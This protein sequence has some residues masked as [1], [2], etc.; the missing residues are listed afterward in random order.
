[1][2]NDVIFTNNLIV[3]I[4]KIKVYVQKNKT[5][6]YSTITVIIALACSNLSF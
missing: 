1:M 6:Y 3:N 4:E 5:F 2:E